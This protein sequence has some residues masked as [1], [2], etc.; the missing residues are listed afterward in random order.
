M[1]VQVARPKTRA[2]QLALI[3]QRRKHVEQLEAMLALPMPAQDR[4]HLQQRL[5]GERA[6]LASW[7]TWVARKS[8]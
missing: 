7:E 5:Q 2:G 1:S 8:A 4:R 3:R 6:S